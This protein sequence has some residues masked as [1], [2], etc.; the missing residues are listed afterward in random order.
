MGA[1]LNIISKLFTP[2]GE[3]IVIYDPPAQHAR[4]IAESL[5]IME[6]TTNPSTYFDRYT[7]ASN[8]SCMISQYPY[9]IYKGKT[10][11]QI[12]QMLYDGRSKD[13]LHREFI[14]RLFA[15]GKEDTL[16]YQ[17]Y[18]YGLDMSKSTREYFVKK[19]SGKKYHFCKVRFGKENSKLYTYVTKDKSISEGDTVTVPTGNCFVPEST[20]LQVV[21]VYDGSLDELCFPIESLRCVERKLK[22]ISCPHCGAHIQVVAKGNAGKCQYCDAEFY[23]I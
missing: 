9:A 1:I 23:F 21:E 16:T 5:S 19:L 22:S 15:A 13:K 18:D 2:Q 6:K 20:V 3:Q 8:K 10:A 14:D 7:L 11:S 12:H 4:I 17:L